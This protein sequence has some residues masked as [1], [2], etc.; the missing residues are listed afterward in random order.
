MMTVENHQDHG[1]KGTEGEQLS[2]GYQLIG[3]DTAGHETDP[4]LHFPVGEEGEVAEPIT[5]P[6]PRPPRQPYLDELKQ[7]FRIFGENPTRVYASAAVG[8]GIL[9]GITVAIISW[10]TSTA[11]GPYDMRSVLAS[12]PGLKG[13]LFLEWDR[14]L[15]YRLSFEP[16]YPDQLAGF[17]LVAANAPRPLS[18]TL[19]LQ[20]AEGFVLCTKD[21]LVKYDARKAAALAARD[22]AALEGYA[23]KAELFGGRLTPG[24]DFAQLNAIETARERGKDI[25]QN[26]SG[27]GGQVEAIKAEGV[28]PCP[29]KA[30]Q[31]TTSWSFTSNF[32]TLAEQNELRKLTLPKTAAPAEKKKAPKPASRVSPFYIEGDDAFAA[33]DP[34][35][36]LIETLSGRRFLIDKTSGEANALKSVDFPVTVHYKCDQGANC[37]ITRTGASP[38]HSK[39]RR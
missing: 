22:P 23:D 28:F 24:M 3:S 21:V 31:T 13:H 39:L 1:A 20:N 14:T 18:F 4:T 12:G 35:T 7:Q 38:L 26:Q 33:Y 30:Y 34:S 27:P 17:S 5:A 37:T 25:F 29:A 36:G 9:F 6:A 32:P 2:L 11:T 16:T 19:Q 15:K 10:N 8:L